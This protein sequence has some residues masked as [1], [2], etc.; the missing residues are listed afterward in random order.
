MATSYVGS[1]QDVRDRPRSVEE[2]TDE[3]QKY[4]YDKLV[5]LKYWLRSAN[6]MLREVDN[7]AVLKMSTN[8]N[9]GTGR[10]SR[11]E[12]RRCSSI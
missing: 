9:G 1:G 6:N 5:P 4:G 7:R 11:E 2:I 12:W 3:A 10:P 8:S